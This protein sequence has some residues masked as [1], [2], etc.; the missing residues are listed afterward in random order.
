MQALCAV[1]CVTLVAIVVMILMSFD[2]LEY[3]EMGLNYS[4][5]SDTVE[6]RAYTSGRYYLGV[7]NHFIKFP[8]V[9]RSIFFVQSMDVK[10]VQGMQGG[11]NAAQSAYSGPPLQSRT[12]DGLNVRLEV[13]FQYKLDMLK[14]YELFSTLGPNYEHT[15]VRM[16]IEQ[17]TISATNHA[18]HFFFTN[19]S[20]I[21]LEMH[22]ELQ[23]HFKLYAFSEVPFFQL[24]TVHLPG[25]FEE[26]LR[27]TQVKQQEIQIAK[28]EQ[29]TNSVSYQTTVLQ[30]EQEINVMM[31]QAEAEAAAIKAANE[32]YC[33][34]YETTQTKQADALK[35]LVQKSGWTSTELLEYMKIRAMR[36]HPS[37]KTTIRI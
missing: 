37:E 7:G 31:N 4:W 30:A 19:R 21:G 15:L 27:Q 11:S 25:E 8:R 22:N 26:A 12:R 29:K 14:L 3:Q 5:L 16:A 20:T 36:E 23:N 34:Q 17:I 10:A 13:S 18:A 1:A 6:N 24:R 32:A 33:T 9:V 28:L 2:S 35:M